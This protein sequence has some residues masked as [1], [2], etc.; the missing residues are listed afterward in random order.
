MPSPPPVG[1]RSPRRS[2]L[3]LAALAPLAAGCASLRGPAAAPAAPAA[4]APGPA[5]AAAPAPGS[6]EEGLAALRAR[7]V[8]PE[9][10]PAF[11]F[12]PLGVRGG[13]PTP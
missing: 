9:T 13:R 12:R 7:R 11:V 3:R 5:P 6:A 8:A 4:P 2:F 10:E 1:P